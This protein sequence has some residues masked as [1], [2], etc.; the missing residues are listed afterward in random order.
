MSDALVQQLKARAAEP[1]TATD[2]GMAVSVP[3]PMTEDEL[4]AVEAIL[5]FALPELLRRLYGEVANGGFGPAYGLLG[6]R[7]GALNED[8]LDAIGVYLRFRATD[9]HDPHWRWPERLLPLGHLGCGMFLCVDCT[10]PDGSLVWFEPNPH[11]Q[12][13]PWDDSFIPFPVDL[14]GWLQRWLAGAPDLLE[15]AWDAEFGPDPQAS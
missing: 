15:T 2:M 5:G 1:S 9:A 14:A 8:R 13:A 3:S 10:S 7:G 6:L 11:E 12:G 4:R